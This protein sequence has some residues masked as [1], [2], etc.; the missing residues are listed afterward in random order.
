[1]TA[2]IATDKLRALSNDPF[3][4]ANQQ[5][6]HVHLQPVDLIGQFNEMISKLS[7]SSLEARDTTI[8]ALPSGQDPQVAQTT[9]ST[10]TADGYAREEKLVQK[11][12]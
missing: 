6:L 7:S 5:H 11:E 3:S 10:E 9:N 1:V 4:Q 8:K 12:S 2:G